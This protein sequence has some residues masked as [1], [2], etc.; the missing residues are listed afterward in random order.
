M[1]TL[2]F[3]TLISFWLAIIDYRSTGRF[4]V[5]EA[6]SAF[7]ITFQPIVMLPFVIAFLIEVSRLLARSSN[8]VKL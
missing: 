3:A 5:T 7:P 4:T 2:A 8:P 6:L 1:W